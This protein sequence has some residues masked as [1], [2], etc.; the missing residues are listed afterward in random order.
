LTIGLGKSQEE[1]GEI[2]FRAIKVLIG[3][4]KLSREDILTLKSGMAVCLIANMR[5]GLSV[6][7]V[8]KVGLPGFACNFSASSLRRSSNGGS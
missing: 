5:G 3:L 7:I 4:I 2:R 1:V 6:K 8:L